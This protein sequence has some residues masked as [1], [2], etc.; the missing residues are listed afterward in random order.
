MNF[1]VCN[2]HEQWIFIPCYNLLNRCL[3]IRYLLDV[4]VRAWSCQM[5]PWT[6]C[7]VYS[8][9]SIQIM[10]VFTYPEISFCFVIFPAVVVFSS[11]GC[12]MVFTFFWTSK[13]IWLLGWSSASNRARGIIQYC[14]R[15]VDF[16]T[17]ETFSHVT[18]RSF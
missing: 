1:P 10:C 5:K 7:V 15:K 18:C 14:S 9:C 8:N 16:V 17:L 6:S 13:C 2:Y 12:L 3:C 4:I 11:W